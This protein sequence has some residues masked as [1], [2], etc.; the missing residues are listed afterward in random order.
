MQIAHKHSGE[1]IAADSRTIYRGLD[2]GT[3]KPTLEDQQ[4]VPH[5]GLDLRDPDES[6]NAAEFKQIA[7]QAIADIQ[8]RGKL[9]VL[10]GG[11]GLYVD[12]V[13]FD[14]QFG[15]A[16]DLAERERL[17]ALPIV[18]L[19]NLCRQKNID[20]PINNNNRRHLVRA[21]ELGGLLKHKKTLRDDTLVVGIATDRA[22]LRER[23][24]QRA[25][26]MVN[27]GVLGEVATAGARYGWK[28]EALK[29]NIYRIFRKVVEGSEPLLGAIDEFVRGDMALAKRQM[30]WL[31]RNSHIVWSSDPAELLERVDT[32]LDQRSK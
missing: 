24:E 22:T 5:Y 28:G 3:A 19:Q 1:I 15:D 8:A 27:A 31:K 11:T 32:F 26:A 12:A 23:I 29:G 16:A 7:V 6:F 20:M 25:H 18:E 10:V 21:I 30:T 13:L 2:I 14:Y 4:A 17:S 9:P